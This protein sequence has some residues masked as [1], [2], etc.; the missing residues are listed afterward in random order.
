MRDRSNAAPVPRQAPAPAREPRDIFREVAGE[1]DPPAN[2]T[3]K[4]APAP[5]PDN[6]LP[7]AA[8]DFGGDGGVS[9]ATDFPSVNSIAEAAQAESP[10][11]DAS[12]AMSGGDGDVA[13]EVDEPPRECTG[14]ES[15]TA[16]AAHGGSDDDGDNPAS[17]EEEG[18]ASENGGEPHRADGNWIAVDDLLSRRVSVQFSVTGTTPDGRLSISQIVGLIRTDPDIREKV[19]RVR[20]A[21]EEG[22]DPEIVK[23]LKRQLPVFTA[24]GE[25]SIR[26]TGGITAHSGLLQ[27]DFDAIAPCDVD[28]VLRR[29]CADPHVLV[30]FR[31]PSGNV[32]VLVAIPPDPGLHRRSFDAVKRHFMD[33]HGLV[34]DTCTKDVPRACY[35]SHDPEPYVASGEVLRFEPAA[36][37]R[38]A[39]GPPARL[40]EH[41]QADGGQCGPEPAGQQ[42]HPLALVR[43]ALLAIPTRPDYDEWIKCIAAV[44]DAMPDPAVA[45]PLLRE[46]SPEESPRQYEVKWR[47]GLRHIPAAWLFDQARRHGWTPINMH[48]VNLRELQRLS[49]EEREARRGPVI[50]DCILRQGNVCL[51][52]G[53]A[54]SR[55]SFAV[56]DMAI[57]VV[58]GGR[59]FV[60]ASGTGFQT[61]AARVLIY[62]LEMPG[63]E[64]GFRLL[65][66]LRCRAAEDIFQDEAPIDQ[67]AVYSLRGMDV[68]NPLEHILEHI[69]LNA[70]PGDLVIVDCLY[71]LI[72]GDVSDMAEVAAPLRRFSR[73]A[74]QTRCGI[75]IVDHFRKGT[76]GKAAD[77][78]IGSA[79]KSMVPDT[80][81]TIE[82]VTENGENFRIGIEARTFPP[83]PPFTIAYDL[84]L[85]RFRMSSPPPPGES[86]RSRGLRALR[87]VWG[88][89]P[90]ASVGREE[91]ELIW[92]VRQTQATDTLNCFQNWHWIERQGAGSATRY[93]LL[94]EGRA[95]LEASAT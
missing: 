61:R 59:L 19:E 52:G 82:R 38:P 21:I 64:T 83:R 44:K 11:E 20:G 56:L 80:I 95:Q 35:F 33:E 53:R 5:S 68:A 36:D 69:R 63:D 24:S 26:N 7:A 93:A 17:G 70:R 67:I 14:G 91:C 15:P 86:N 9:P 88:T 27:G 81:M 3:D 87:Q 73:V 45:L 39:N 77:Q 42:H 6:T 29:V 28:D 25:F 79:A 12:G 40:E 37:E 22:A 49:P 31:S 55:K 57:T 72:T 32:K 34:M 62:D 58:S 76:Q 66:A 16:G 84:N 43:S 46:W 48:R 78:I 30:A 41:R 60:S 50:I 74:E 47:E 65:D 13:R 1:D 94:P 8:G 10:S 18:A 51:F 89:N 75:I 71:A 4:A 90:A 85:K 92:D 54:K 2:A 23:G